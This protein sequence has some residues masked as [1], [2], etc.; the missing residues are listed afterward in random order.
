MKNTIGKSIVSAVMAAVMCLSLLPTTAFAA[1]TLEKGWH[2][3]E[4]TGTRFFIDSE[5]ARHD[6]AGSINAPEKDSVGQLTHGTLGNDAAWNLDLN[7]GALDIVG[8]GDMGDDYFL[9]YPLYTNVKAINIEN[10]ITAIGDNSFSGTGD[11]KSV[12][13]PDS[14]TSIGVQAF[15]DCEAMQTVSMSSNVTS[16]G[17]YAFL[18]CKSLTSIVVPEGVTKLDNGTFMGCSNLTSVTLPNSLTSIGTTTSQT[19]YYY[20]AFGGCSALKSITLPSN[21]KSIEQEAFSGCKSLTSLVIPDSVTNIGNGTF[22]GLGSLENLTIGNGVTDLSWAATYPKL[23]SLTIG[24]GVKT[25]DNAF[26]NCALETVTIPD[27]VTKID[28]YS[29]NSCKNLK[30]ITIPDSVTSIGLHV[31]RDCPSLTIYGYTGSPAEWQAKDMSV[32]FVSLG[33]TAHSTDKKPDSKPQPDDAPNLSS[34]SEWAYDVLN[35]AYKAG[36]IPEALQASYT[37]ATTRAEFCALAVTLY[38]TASGKEITQ[39]KTFTDTSD[40]NVEKAAAMGIVDG[41]GDNKFE[42]N[43]SLTREQAATMI[44][45]I[46]MAMKKPLAAQASTFADN[47]SISDW[48]AGAVG[49]MQASGVMGGVGE[50][51]FAPKTNYTREQSVTTILRLYKI[52]D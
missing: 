10:G 39:R 34:A 18:G 6:S 46:A 44:A 27:G 21:L 24:S 28:G 16:I 2:N 50:N 17:H 9:P 41:V 1:D 5:G 40:V 19:N 51:T 8:N 43:A 13:I 22:A 38:E 29:F 32:P 4:Q 14:V 20:G 30:S 49:Q 15:R 12:I 23:K 3:D 33:T 48:A 25:I 36:L 11:V 37:Q 31:L 26:G 45:R 7:T 35:E 47:A 52:V 42:P